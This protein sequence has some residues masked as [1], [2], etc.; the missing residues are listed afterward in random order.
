MLKFIGY[1]LLFISL[2]PIIFLYLVC[3]G[4]IIILKNV[5]KENVYDLKYIDQS[6]GYTFENICA[7]I[8]KANKYTYVNVT[9]GS[10]DFG[11][12]VIAE[13]DSIKYAIQCK[14]YANNVGIAAVQQAF[15]GCQYYN[16]DIP[17]VLTNNYFTPQAIEMANSTNVELWDRTTLI[18]LNK[19]K[20]EHVNKKQKH[21]KH[22]TLQKLMF[23]IKTLIFLFF[24][25]PFFTLPNYTK[26][27]IDEKTQTYIIC[28]IICSCCF[29][30][31][32]RYLLREN[33]NKKICSTEIIIED[34]QIE[35]DLDNFSEL[36]DSF[37][38]DSYYNID[39]D[40]M[41]TCLQE[42]N[43]N[44]NQ[45]YDKSM[46]NKEKDHFDV[47]NFNPNYT[48][49]LEEDFKEAYQSPTFIIP[50]KDSDIDNI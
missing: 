10:G 3:K 50:E 16:C 23:H 14:H 11:I 27:T 25:S 19:I 37:K 18:K 8:L 20:K 9:K 44:N 21:S 43:S 39:K 2:A 49:T 30:S 5:N 7:N 4:I 38:D 26:L 47:D 29:I 45:Y 34:E 42:M 41:K 48:T 17:V 40:I 35:N 36:E 6:D 13:K 32:L 46:E 24:I 28:F 12:D 15:S 1:V 31:N 33:K 22:R